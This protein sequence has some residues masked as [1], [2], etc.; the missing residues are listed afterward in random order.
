MLIF[1]KTPFS[2]RY[3]EKTA[4]IKSKNIDNLIQNKN[5]TLY[6]LIECVIELI[7]NQGEVLPDNLA[8][9]DK[10]LFLSM[11]FLLESFFKQT[12]MLYTEAD[13]KNDLKSM[14]SNDFFLNNFKN[15]EKKDIFISFINI[16]IEFSSSKV[17]CYKITVNS[18]FN[19][20]LSFFTF[21]NKLVLKLENTLENLLSMPL[22]KAEECLGNF[23]ATNKNDVIP[24]NPIEDLISSLLGYQYIESQ[25]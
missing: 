19:D 4:M 20:D 12:Y 8:S 9:I 11:Q 10:D 25:K 7:N 15:T 16:L 22:N 3:D 14:A 18:E 21:P 13:F 24:K 2:V 23:I 1:Y 5:H 17:N 6:H